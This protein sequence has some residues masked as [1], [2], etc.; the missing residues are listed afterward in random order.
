MLR[1]P[2]PEMEFQRGQP[3]LMGFLSEAITAAA[4]D[5]QSAMSPFTECIILATIS[6]RALLHQHQSLVENIYANQS[7][8]FWDRHE[9]I[10]AILTKRMQILSLKYPHASQHADPMLLFTSMVAQ[11][12]VLYLYK[13]M[14]GVT[15]ATAKNRALMMEYERCSFVAAQEIVYLTKTLAQLSCFKA[16]PL[17]LLPGV[18]LYSQVH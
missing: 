4:D 17:N 7:Q 1:L 5:H 3:I 14:E 12:T 8:D 6:G 2:A 16:R 9:W 11:A 10:S 18:G 15:P 13:V